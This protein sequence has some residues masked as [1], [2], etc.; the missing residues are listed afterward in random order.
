LPI[1]S[2]IFFIVFILSAIPAI[3]M[4]FAFKKDDFSISEVF[5]RG[6][7]IDRDIEKYVKIKYVRL[8]KILLYIGIGS[9]LFC[10][11]FALFNM[12]SEI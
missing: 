11:L 7:L 8:I 3:I 6:S 5:W 4:I 2:K 12:F 1:I 10:I 9:F